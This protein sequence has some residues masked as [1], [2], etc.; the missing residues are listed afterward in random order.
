MLVPVSWLKEFVEIKLPLNKLMWRM[1]E[2]G[3]TTES[4]KKIG[5]EIVLEV[6]V[7]PNRP[8]W[9]SIVGI[10][11]EIAAIES[12]KVKLPFIPEIPKPQKILP[13]TF[14][15]NF[16]LIERW[17]AIILTNVQIKPS[18]KFIQERLKLVGLR[19]IN[20]VVDITN[21]VM[22]ELGIPMHAFDYDEIKG[23]IMSLELSKG[24][25]KFTSVDEITYELPK[26][27]MIIKDSERIIDLI[28]I[29]GG[30]N[31]GISEKTKNVLLHVTIDNPVLIRRTSQKLGLRSEAS[32][33]Y[34]RGPDKGGTLNSLKRAYF[35]LTKYAN[36]VLASKVYDLKEKEFSP[37][38]LKLNLDKLYKV[39]GL[40][41]PKEKV[42]E[43][44]S[45]LGLS[46]KLSKNN[47]VCTIPTYRGDLK[48]EE[49]LIEEIARFYGYNNFP[50]TLPAG[51]VSSIKVP[52]YYDRNFELELK[53]L[54]VSAGFHEV[55]TL[56][57]VSSDL[58]K[59]TLLKPEDHIKLSNP[60]SSEYEY[61]RI[62]II[63][64]LLSALKL[65]PNEP[66]FKIFEY[67][68]V[69]FEVSEKPLEKYMLSA[70]EKNTDFRSLKGT[71]DLILE[72]L[73]IVNY[74][75]KPQVAK[76]NFWHPTK[77]GVIEIKGEIIGNFGE[78]HPLVLENLKIK[79]SVF[80]FEFDVS[81]LRNSQGKKQFKDISNYPPQVEDLT[82]ILPERIRVGDV[83][84]KIKSLDDK[85]F[86]VFL[87][88]LYKNAYTFRIYYQDFE[89]TLTDSEV[90]AIRNKILDNLKKE[91]G[92][93]QKL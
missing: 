73:N 47:I 74:E 39:L 34:E 49:D 25:E 4:Y 38:K 19:P 16:K 44:L 60:V 72:K 33:I 68:K 80:A 45:S 31:S 43:I 17:S 11:R 70:L 37:W 83:I 13:I 88:D 26:D 63:P 82:L 20:N 56:S 61:L 9:M 46:P 22:F 57:L 14:K 91:F 59:Q 55:F 36:A 71:I 78:I 66:S 48:I 51:Q 28:G 40:K 15:T 3:I 5:N 54:M 86:S 79:D 2:V 18:P 23:N 84:K 50:K 64:S 32:A 42:V 41:I 6:E 10:A 1:T 76:S 52:Y 69:Y 87:K 24:G 35:L 21:Y 85:I 77:S 67:N 65:N 12:E 53:N 29:K 7:T 89:K 58:I 27:A 92:I 93:I 62:S 75:V 81:S 8:D 30:A 90:K